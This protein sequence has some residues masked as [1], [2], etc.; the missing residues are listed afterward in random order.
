MFHS[1]LMLF[2]ISFEYILTW[3]D[4]PTVVCGFFTQKENLTVVELVSWLLKDEHIIFTGLLKDLSPVYTL[5]TMDAILLS[6]KSRRENKISWIVYCLTWLGW[7]VKKSWRVLFA[8]L[9]QKEEE[10]KKDLRADW[11]N[12]DVWYKRKIGHIRD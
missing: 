2:S 6:N 11:K 8:G 12:S 3:I 5:Q 10:N 4:S 9:S 1:Y 7:K